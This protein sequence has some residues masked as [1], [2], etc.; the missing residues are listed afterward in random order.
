MN[1]IK[2]YYEYL[3]ELNQNQICKFI[4]ICGRTCYKSQLGDAIK[5]CKNLIING[6]ESVLEHYS[7][8][9]KFVVDR[10]FSHELVRHR[11]AAYSQESTRYC[12]YSGG[13]TFII[14]PWLNISEGELLAP[15]RHQKDLFIWTLALCYAEE[16]YRQLLKCGW[17]PQQARSVLPNALKTEVVTT[18]NLRMWRHVLR[19]RTTDKCHPQMLEIMRPLLLDLKQKLPVFFEDL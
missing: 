14:P 16:T 9:V 7:F 11:L 10:G 5:F 18:F 13:V 8:T 2:P 3:T 6:H 19:Q 17:T 4:E 15:E 12:N 1:L